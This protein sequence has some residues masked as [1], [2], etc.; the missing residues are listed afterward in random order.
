MQ[1]LDRFCCSLADL[2]GLKIWSVASPVISPLKPWLYL[3]SVVL[4]VGAFLSHVL[5]TVLPFPYLH[6]TEYSHCRIM[7]VYFTSSRF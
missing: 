3:R 6:K 2:H 4:V 7:F 5:A 1:I